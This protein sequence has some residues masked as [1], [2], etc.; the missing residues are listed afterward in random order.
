MQTGEGR[1]DWTVY[2]LKCADGSLYTGITNRLFHRLQAHA[3]GRGAK[4]TRGRGPFSLLYT[5]WHETK[6][7][8]LQREAVIKSLSRAAKFG[9]V[10]A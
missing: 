2:I 8:A 4:Y 6:G 1:L 7:I 5:E 3:R 10:V 9:L